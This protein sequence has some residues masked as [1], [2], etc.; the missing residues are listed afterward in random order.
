MKP[1]L[2]I[3]SIR[4]FYII[5]LSARFPYIMVDITPFVVYPDEASIA[6]AA[7]KILGDYITYHL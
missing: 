6:V 3:S 2:K 1:Y 5:I 4:L 7:I